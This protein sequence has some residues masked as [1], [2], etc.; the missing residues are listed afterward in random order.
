MVCI[1]DRHFMF[2]S[3]IQCLTLAAIV[4]AWASEFVE[5][6]PGLSSEGPQYCWSEF[7]ESSERDELK[8]DF[9]LA[10]IACVVPEPAFYGF[11]RSEARLVRHD[12]AAFS[13]SRLRGPPTSAALG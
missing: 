12:L 8:S 4:M 11:I 2:R 7:D 3:A 6:R 1:Y 13:I 9:L 5:L 10:N